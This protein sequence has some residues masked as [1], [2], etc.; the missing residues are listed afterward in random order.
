MKKLKA[1]IIGLGKMG[2]NHER[3]LSNLEHV[4]YIGAVDPFK[5]VNKKN[6][7]ADIDQLISQ[8]PDYCVIASSTA[9]HS[10][11]A[12]KLLQN[13]INC[14][15]EKPLALDY[16]SAKNISEVA[17]ANS[18]VAGV[19]YIERYNS[20]AQNLKHK[21]ESNLI[22]KIIQISAK[23][24][25]PARTGDVNT[26]VVLDLAIHDIDLILWLTN[27]NFDYVYAEGNK[28][29]LTHSEDLV[30]INGRL[31]NNCI[32]DMNVNRKS[33]IKKRRIDF[34]G[35][36]GLLSL[37][38]LKSSLTL[39]SPASK[40]I[41]YQ[42]VAHYQGNMAG[43]AIT[44]AFEKKEPLAV[45]HQNFRDYLLDGS[46]QIASLEDGILGIKIAEKIIESMVESKVV[47]V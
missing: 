29:N 46:G 3:I 37:D 18:M 8:N 24:Y 23:R 33:P 19:G 35:E 21:I 4:D 45:E 25:G 6:L 38:T 36:N 27:M 11:I 42:S 13:G 16:N 9:T 47:K 15:I 41:S 20:A 39:F 22:G 1:G 30:S 12:I 26:G 43:E 14:L 40:S 2:E 34:L 5:T 31:I 28:D 32:F 17:S 7:Y 44:Y 10:E